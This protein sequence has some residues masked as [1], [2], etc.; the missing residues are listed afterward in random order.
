MAKFLSYN[1]RYLDDMR[2]VKLKYFGDFAKDIYD[3]TLLLKACACSYKQGTF[4]ELYT[5]VVDGKCITGICP[6]VDDF[7]FEEVN[8]PVPQSKINSMLDYTTFYSQSIHFFT[9]CNNLND[10]L[11]RAKLKL[12]QVGETWLL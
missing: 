2:T 3:S 10:F 8:Y 5:L 4:L 6:K 7:N 9:L 12:F 11:F 1:C